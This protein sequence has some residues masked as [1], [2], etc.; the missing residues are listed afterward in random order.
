LP[1]SDDVIQTIEYCPWCGAR[2]PSSLRDEYFERLEQLGLEPEPAAYRSIF[3]RMRG[4]AW[5]DWTDTASA[6]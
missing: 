3:G 1:L 6:A 5:R 2:L 4:G